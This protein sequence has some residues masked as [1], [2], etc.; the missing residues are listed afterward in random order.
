MMSR[1][2]YLRP[3]V[4]ELDRVLALGGVVSLALRVV[5]DVP[6]VGVCHVVSE[7]IICWHLNRSLITEFL[8]TSPASHLTQPCEEQHEGCEGREKEEE[9]EEQGG[10][11]EEQ[12]EG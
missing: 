7:V 1:A 6:G 2:W 8:I 10:E 12:Y 9:H 5:M 4:R 3:A 11:G